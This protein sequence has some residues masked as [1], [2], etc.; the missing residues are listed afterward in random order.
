MSRSASARPSIE[1]WRVSR[2]GVRIALLAAAA[3]YE[4]EIPE[5]G[6]DIAGFRIVDV[7]QTEPVEKSGRLVR[8]RWYELRADLV[9]SYILPPVEV[10]FRAVPPTGEEPGPWQTIST[11]ELFVEVE[12]VLPSDGEATD[13]RGLKPLREVRPGLDWRLLV[14]ILVAGLALAGLAVWLVK[15]RAGRG[16]TAP[17]IPAHELAFAALGRLRQT[18]FENPRAVR[19][20]YFQISEV[21]RAYVEGRFEL[22]ATDLTTEEIVTGLASLQ[23]MAADQNRVL[24]EFLVATDQVKFAHREP[25]KTDIEETYEQALGFVEATRPMAEPLPEEQ[26]A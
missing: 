8:E 23:E 6:A 5:A 17:P 13:I 25:T 9:G 19:R 10:A 24:K 16:D 18:D 7:G 22:N 21:L 20:F 15:R 1:P 4:V 2:R 14:A 3:D 11:S 26:A 12:S